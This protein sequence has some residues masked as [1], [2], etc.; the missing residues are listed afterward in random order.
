MFLGK[1]FERGY[2]RVKLESST[3][4]FAA[5]RVVRLEKVAAVADGRKYAAWAS[6]S[7]LCIVWPRTVAVTVDVT[8]STDNDSTR[9]YPDCSMAYP[10]PSYQKLLCRQS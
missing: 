3:K 5:Q 7:T 8:C 10:A 4:Y 2:G 9:W 1:G 6:G